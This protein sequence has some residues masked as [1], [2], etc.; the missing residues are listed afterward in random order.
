[1]FRKETSEGREV[2]DLIEKGK[3]VAGFLT[4]PN[5]SIFY[6][7][8]QHHEGG[9]YPITCYCSESTTKGVKV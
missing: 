9:S 1:M 3:M 2:Q 8:K 7:I 6:P 4:A 5:L